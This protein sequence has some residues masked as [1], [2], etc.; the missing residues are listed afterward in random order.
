[1][2]AAIVAYAL[3]AVGRP[4]SETRNGP[5]GVRCSI[6]AAAARHAV[7]GDVGDAVEGLPSRQTRSA[8]G[9]GRCG[10]GRRIVSAPIDSVRGFRGQ[11]SLSRE[12]LTPEGERD[13]A[14]W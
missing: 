9:R 12:R 4:G 10:S 1:V 5:T 3:V 8:G 11:E 7:A 2:D 6:S 13:E 14:G